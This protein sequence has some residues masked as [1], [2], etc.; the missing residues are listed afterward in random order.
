MNIFLI[1]L[2]RQVLKHNLKL[3]QH[4]IPMQ[5]HFNTFNENFILIFLY[6]YLI[7]LLLFLL[8]YF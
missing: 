1:K 7:N 4:K 6:L 2:D 3:N 8:L 5:N